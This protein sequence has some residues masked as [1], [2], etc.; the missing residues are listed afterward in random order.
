V[1]E[2][3]KLTTV[4]ETNQTRPWESYIFVNSILALIRDSVGLSKHC[5]VA[6]F[7]SLWHAEQLNGGL[8]DGVTLAR[9]QR[10]CLTAITLHEN[11]FIHS[12]NIYKL[13]TVMQALCL[14]GNM[15][16]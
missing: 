7:V 16:V 2:Q 11:S 3:Q 10:T 4:I 1:S 14:R 12:G 13:S 8:Q 9:I 6:C 15:G 5:L